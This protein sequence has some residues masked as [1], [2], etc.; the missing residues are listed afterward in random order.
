MHGKLRKSI[1]IISECMFKI[2]NHISDLIVNVLSSSVVDHG[3][4]PRL[5]QTKDHKLI[6]LILP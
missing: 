4:E 3:F 5:G 2:Q 1:I 6:L